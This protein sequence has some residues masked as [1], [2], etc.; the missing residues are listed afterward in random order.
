[1]EDYREYRF[2]VIKN[3]INLKWEG[4]GS[5]IENMGEFD[6]LQALFVLETLL[7]IYSLSTTFSLK[8]TRK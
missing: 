2:Y 6:E 3:F 8:K 4:E 5:I 7:D 1:M